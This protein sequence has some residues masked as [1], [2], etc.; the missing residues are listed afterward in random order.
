MQSMNVL[1]GLVAAVSAFPFHQQPLGV[2]SERPKGAPDATEPQTAT[3]PRPLHGKFLHVT[4]TDEW[5]GG[6]A[7][8]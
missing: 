1:L 3:S 5:P 8:V 7:Q 6:C 4:G 2:G